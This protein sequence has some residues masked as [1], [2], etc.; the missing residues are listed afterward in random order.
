[1]SKR[2]SDDTLDFVANYNGYLGGTLTSRKITSIHL[3]F[4]GLTDEGYK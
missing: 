1:M 3:W 4:N 2:H